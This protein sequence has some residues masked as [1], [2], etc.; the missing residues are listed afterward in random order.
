[1]HAESLFIKLRRR[2]RVRH[3]YGDMTQ[4]SSHEIAPSI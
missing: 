1:M 4:L 2:V 3:G